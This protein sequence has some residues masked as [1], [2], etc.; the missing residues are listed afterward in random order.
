MDQNKKP[1]EDNITDWSEVYRVE[2]DLKI[3][4][5]RSDKLVT[6]ER[7]KNTRKD[8]VEPPNVQDTIKHWAEVYSIEEDPKPNE[9]EYEGNQI[10][11][12]VKKI[13]SIL[14][15]TDLDSGDNT[16][17]MNLKEVKE[18]PAPINFLQERIDQLRN[19]STDNKT[20]DLKPR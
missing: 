2:D 3:D 18:L 19:N 20:K 9:L 14:Y 16:I 10:L 15:F 6:E 7:E 17:D 4:L 1:K 12:P 11:D 5:T 8:A 13:K